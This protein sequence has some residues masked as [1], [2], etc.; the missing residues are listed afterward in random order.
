MQCDPGYAVNPA[1]KCQLCTVTIGFC[2][3]CASIDVCNTCM[4]GYNLVGLSSC[5][6]AA[7]P[8]CI[9]CKNNIALCD[10]C[11]NDQYYMATP[12]SC[13]LCKNAIP[14]CATC[15]PNGTIC[16]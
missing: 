13:A 2:A 4:A 9:G 1:F 10:G 15:T 16:Y 14:F 6:T 5:C 8:Y 12:I 11:I 3:T 7:M